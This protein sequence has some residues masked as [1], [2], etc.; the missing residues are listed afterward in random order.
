MDRFIS[1]LFAVI[2]FTWIVPNSYSQTVNLTIDFEVLNTVAGSSYDSR[3]EIFADGK[4]VGTS[5]VKDQQIPNSIT[6]KIPTGRYELKAV[7]MAN[8]EGKW[9]KRT[10]ANG[11][12]NDFFWLKERNFNKDLTVKLY[13]DIASGVHEKKMPKPKKKK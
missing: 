4:N 12:S 2:G 3:L 1:F 13:F 10:I 8:Y 5:E 9:Q 11:Y 7:L 6:V